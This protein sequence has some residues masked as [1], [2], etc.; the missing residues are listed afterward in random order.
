M[1]PNGPSSSA[2][3]ILLERPQHWAYYHPFR[4][5]FCGVTSV[6]PISYE[7]RIEIENKSI[8]QF[9]MADGYHQ[10]RTFNWVAH[11]CHGDNNNDPICWDKVSVVVVDG[12]GI[13][14][15]AFPVD[16]EVRCHY[17]LLGVWRNQSP[18][19]FLFP[20]L[21]FGVILLLRELNLRD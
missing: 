9:S 14:L 1:T 2:S 13:I 19:Q 21:R 7:M 11:V 6:M 12:S 8:A 3:N 17:D 10:V 15:I 20:R 5:Y 18:Y 4:L 16:S